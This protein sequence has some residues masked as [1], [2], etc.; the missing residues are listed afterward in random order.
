MTTS[1]LQTKPNPSPSIPVVTESVFVTP[2]E[3][4]VLAAVMMTVVATL[5]LLLLRGGAT[6]VGRRHDHIVV[7]ES[8]IR[9]V[10][11]VKTLGHGVSE[12]SVALW[13]GWQHLRD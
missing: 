2:S 8:C 9:N 4:L 5:M 3:T 12:G 13:V 10:I 11:R 1:T 7:A 6:V